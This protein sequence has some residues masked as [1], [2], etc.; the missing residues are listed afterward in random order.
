MSE[1]KTDVDSLKLSTH[2]NTVGIAQLTHTLEQRTREL[3]ALTRANQAAIAAGDK[4]VAA[5]LALDLAACEKAAADARAASAEELAE[6]I[7]HEAQLLQD[8]ISGMKYMKWGLILLA[9][10]ALVL[11][12]RAWLYPAQSTVGGEPHFADTGARVVRGALDSALAAP[13]A[14]SNAVRGGWDMLIAF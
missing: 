7:R 6:Q 14:I 1:L 12:V 11:V 8:E 10:V 4:A 3:E 9:L 2:N 13:S 5:Q